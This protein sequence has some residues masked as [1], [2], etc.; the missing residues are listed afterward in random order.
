MN[1]VKLVPVRM[2]RD[3]MALEE[4]Q[5]FNCGSKDHE[6]PLADWIKS[7]SAAQ[8]AGGCKVWLYRL[9]TDT[10]PLVGYGSLSTGKIETTEA[11]G[12]KKIVKMYEIRMLAL[13]SDYWGKPKGVADREEKFSRQIVRHL[14]REAAQAQ[15]LGQRERLLTLYVHPDASEAQELY[16]A[17]GFQFAPGRFLPDPDIP[18]EKA[19]GLLGMDYAW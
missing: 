13:R 4:V 16:L 11:D 15:R 5:S 12:G 8:I 10:G 6:R 7:E 14:Q 9:E 3:D 19:P 17:C 2:K 18:P 1:A